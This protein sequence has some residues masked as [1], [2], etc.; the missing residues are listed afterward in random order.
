MKKIHLFCNAHLDVIWL[1]TSEEA[2]ATTLSTFRV[3]ADLCEQHDNFVFNHNE[4]LLYQWVE[5]H[6]PQLFERIQK[7]V[8]EGKW[9][10]VGGWILQPDC[11]MPSGESFVRQMLYG[12]AYFKEKFGVEPETA[13][14]FDSFGH[15][16][17]LVQIMHQAGY[18]Y[19]IYMRPENIRM[20]NVPQLFEW[21]GYD[22]ESSIIAYKLNMAYATQFG[23]AADTIKAHMEEYK[24]V[25]ISM[26]TWGIGN[27]GGGP[28]RRDVDD[29]DK[30]MEEYKG[31]VEIVH[32][33]PDAFF[34]E[35]L[36]MEDKLPIIAEDLIP[37]WVGCYSTLV[38]IKQLYRKLENR[39]ISAEKL[40]A[41]AELELGRSYPKKELLEAFRSLAIMQFHDVLPGT[42]T[43]PGEEEVLR[44]GNYGLEL[45]ERIHTN[46]MFALTA[47]EQ[48]AANGAI[49]IFV[50]NPHPYEVDDV[51]ECECM[52]SD[53]NWGDTW[54]FMHAYID[55]EQV[56][57]QNI[58][59]DSNFNLDWRKRVAIKAKF[60]PM[61]I[62]RIDLVPY[63][64]TKPVLKSIEGDNYCFDNK[65]M[66]I[67]I[68]KKTGWI[69][70]YCVDGKELVQPGAF[71]LEVFHDTADPW[72]IDSD[73]IGPK[74]G[75]YELLPSKRAAKVAGVHTEGFE[76]VRIVEDG[77]LFVRVEA[78]FG[79][80]DSTARIMYTLP[81][82]GR[83]FSIDLTSFFA[84]K[85][86]CLRMTI[87]MNMEKPKF[88]GQSVFGDKPLFDD[89]RESESQC[90]MAAYG[91]DMALVVV[92]NGTYGSCNEDNL[93]C[94]TVLRSSTYAGHGIP[95]RPYMEYNR[96]V[97][98]AEQG[99][100][101]FHF[102]ITGVSQ[103][104]MITEAERLAAIE[105]ET[106]RAYN[107]FPGGTGQERQSLLTLSD[108]RIKVAAVKKAEDGN[109]YIVRVFNPENET[110]ETHVSMPLL[111]T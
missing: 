75:E 65:E 29:I 108:A 14:N 89:G 87:P 37:S 99:E 53:Q 104:D 102:R 83:D 15:A 111:G 77:E 20:A 67:K 8:K 59:E 61:A 71:R 98:R 93:L 50:W 49:P 27:H 25:P 30:L 55:G 28:S 52:L 86:T 48:A 47:K 46:A 54:T 51:V 16:Q 105:N 100:R 3:A 23:E 76:P 11:L 6:D 107:I 79:Y 7:L 110:I 35:R 19:Y 5:E 73:R 34:E 33:T 78:I 68:N 57:C 84:E 9:K 22:D 2:I 95:D 44:I 26:R 17:G 88:R 42:C 64:D 21:R 24:D 66:Q 101:N 74:K 40:A 69:D 63:E 13:I 85:D 38:Q 10:I 106:L 62:T 1:W 39:L 43:R 60:K 4:A 81:K 80:E 82:K 41:K 90:W 109:G 92:N 72:R 31:E 103:K 96:Y 97:V 70:S 36:A 12:K 91:N 94:Q 56:P 58:K 32:S 45:V 18:K